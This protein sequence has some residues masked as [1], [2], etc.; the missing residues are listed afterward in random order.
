VT[1]GIEELF[2]LAGVLAFGMAAWCELRVP[3]SERVRRL[4]PPPAARA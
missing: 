2:E 1:Q 4:G 3:L